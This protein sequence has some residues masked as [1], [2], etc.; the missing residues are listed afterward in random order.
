MTVQEVLRRS[1]GWLRDKG[2]ESP[3][4]EAELL[5]AHVLGGER[6]D[7]Y[8]Q[9]DRPLVAPELDAYRTLLRRR[10]AGE[11]SA[12]LTGAREFYGLA[13]EVGPAVLVPRPETELLVDRARELAPR[14]ILEIGTGSA[15]I[16]VT[17]ARRLEDAALVA[18]DV[19]AAALEIARRN[20]ERHGV[21]DRIRFLEGDLFAPL[22]PAG[23]F[24]LIVSNPPYVAE[25]LRGQ[26]RDGDALRHE[27]RGA[28]FA[29]ADGLAVLDP[30][31]AG[32]PARLAEGGTLLVEI[33]EDQEDAVLERAR[34]VFARA[35]VRR[36]L[37]GHPRILEAS[38]PLGAAGE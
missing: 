2:L 8:T 5:L 15:C 36:D 31:V 12:Y 23:R 13:F 30:L 14:R 24:D 38:G 4:L 11:P 27:P 17:C 19:S 33:G 3:R 28:L 32:A 37:A 1:A 21:A 26:A 6:L 18:T 7:L 29:G 25:D 34:R 22:D 10:A 35:E 9:G 16:A 20:A